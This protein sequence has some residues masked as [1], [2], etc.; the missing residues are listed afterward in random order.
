MVV[1]IAYVHSTVP[2]TRFENKCVTPRTAGTNGSVYTILQSVLCSGD[3]GVD[4]MFV[5]RSTLNN[6]E[7]DTNVSVDVDNGLTLVVC[8]SMPQKP[9]KT[10][11]CMRTRCGPTKIKYA[12]PQRARFWPCTHSGATQ[13]SYPYTPYTPYVIKYRTIYVI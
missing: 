9:G 12:Q 7:H 10:I 1:A 4:R 13:L 3:T 11:K 2:C 5:V 8:H 6:N